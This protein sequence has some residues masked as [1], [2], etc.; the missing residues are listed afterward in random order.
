M[1]YEIIAAA[2]LPAAKVLSV[3][4]KLAMKGIVK[5]HPGK[6]VSRS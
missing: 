1:E 6:R 2:G 4:T 3:L 5:N